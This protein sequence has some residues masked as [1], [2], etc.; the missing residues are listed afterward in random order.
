MDVLFLEGSPWSV[1]ATI[2][3]IAADLTNEFLQVPKEGRVMQR[4]PQRSLPHWR[5]SCPPYSVGN[6]F[7]IALVMP[8][9][10]SRYS[11]SKGFLVAG[12]LARRFSRENSIRRVF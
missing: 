4:K 8:G 2:H 12:V 3:H 1:L 11:L 7:E 10:G 5:Q 9:G 6:F